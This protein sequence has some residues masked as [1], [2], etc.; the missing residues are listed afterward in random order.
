MERMRTACSTAFTKDELQRRRYRR[1]SGNG[2][3]I[4]STG[5]DSPRPVRVRR[6][7]PGVRGSTGVASKSNSRR[8]ATAAA[9]E[10]ESQNPPPPPPRR[11]RRHRIIQDDDDPAPSRLLVLLAARVNT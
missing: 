4:A 2:K 9:A 1:V 10:A 3:R 7:V 6:G 11:R 8:E 5:D